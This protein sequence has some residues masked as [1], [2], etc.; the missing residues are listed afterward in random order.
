[1]KTVEMP[2]GRAPL[3]LFP[4]ISSVK[5]TCLN[6]HEHDMVDVGRHGGT[7]HGQDQVGVSLNKNW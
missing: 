7:S 2:M 4:S 5:K 3:M 6:F 1:M